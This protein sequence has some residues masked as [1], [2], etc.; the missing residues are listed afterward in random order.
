MRREDFIS[1]Y[2]GCNL[3]Q[4]GKV[5]IESLQIMCQSIKS[6]PTR[7]PQINSI[8]VGLLISRVANWSVQ[9]RDR[10]VV[11]CQDGIYPFQSSRWYHRMQCTHLLDPYFRILSSW[12]N[13][14]SVSFP[15]RS[16]TTIG[17]SS[18]YVLGRSVGVSIIRRLSFSMRIGTGSVRGQG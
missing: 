11:L 10:P 8:S 14:W 1:L 13:C 5:H 17:V 3:M 15:H 12:N 2:S 9:W 6:S 16:P 18:L 7:K 4:S